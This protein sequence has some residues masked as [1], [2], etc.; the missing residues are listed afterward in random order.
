MTIGGYS[1]N[2]EWWPLYQWLLMD[3]LLVD[4]SVY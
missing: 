2:G 4:I 3:I 1:I